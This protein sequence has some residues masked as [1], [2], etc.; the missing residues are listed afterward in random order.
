MIEA[1]FMYVFHLR[2][3]VITTDVS[4]VCR[5]CFTLGNRKNQSGAECHF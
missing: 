1:N 3:T 4:E 2:V 5:Q